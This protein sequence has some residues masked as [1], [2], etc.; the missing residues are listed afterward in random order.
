MRIGSRN[1]QPSERMLHIPSAADYK[2]YKYHTTPAI[3][4]DQVFIET[5]RLERGPCGYWR[6][7]DDGRRRAFPVPESGYR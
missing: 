1:T 4:Q 5:E 6:R 7:W 3:A 2:G